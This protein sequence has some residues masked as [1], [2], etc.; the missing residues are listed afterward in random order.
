MRGIESKGMLLAAS[1]YDEEEKEHVE[2]LQ[3]TW[4]APGTPVIL[5]GDADSSD[6]EAVKAFYAQKPAAIDA[7][8]FFAAPILIE[9]YIPKIEGKKLLAA[10]KEMKL[11][12]VKTGEAG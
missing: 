10:G 1:W 11:E 5:E 2:L 6:P 7:D 4:A 12:K 8:T 9:D 3:A